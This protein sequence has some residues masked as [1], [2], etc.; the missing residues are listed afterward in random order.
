MRRLVDAFDKNGD[1][2]VSM[3]E[4]L[5]FVGGER[6]PMGGDKQLVLQRKCVWNNNCKKVGG[7]CA[8]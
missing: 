4:F 2:L 1:G 5:D 3:Q 6:G 7:S 8:D